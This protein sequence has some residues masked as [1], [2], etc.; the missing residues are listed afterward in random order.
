MSSDIIMLLVYIYDIVLTDN[1]AQK[2]Q[3]LVTQLDSVFALKD[4]GSR[5]HSLWH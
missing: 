4:L 1:N 3:A 5:Q 2:L